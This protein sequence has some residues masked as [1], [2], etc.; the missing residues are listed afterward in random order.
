MSATQFGNEHS[1]P[2]LVEQ[3][4][5]VP[6]LSDTWLPVHRF[7][8]EQE[9]EALAAA[10]RLG[11]SRRERFRV[12]DCRTERVETEAKAALPRNAQF[13]LLDGAA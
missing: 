11:A 1:R 5:D 9:A 3:H 2:W 6:A 13:S 4:I 12:R 10:M 7:K 8:D